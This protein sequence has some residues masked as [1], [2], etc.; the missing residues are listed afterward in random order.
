MD[1]IHLGN[2]TPLLS[3]SII[4]KGISN[5]EA[6]KSSDFSL[7]LQALLEVAEILT[8]VLDID[9]L[10]PTIME[11]ACSL[12]NTERCSLFLVDQNRTELITR[13]HGGLDKS[14][15]IPIS[16]GIVGAARQPVRL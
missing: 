5:E 8:G 1:A 12:L 10:I 4:G 11:R 7:R 2:M 15:R 13:F 16:R 14:I 3:K 6:L 9:A